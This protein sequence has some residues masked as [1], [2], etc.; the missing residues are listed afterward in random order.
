MIP[1]LGVILLRFAYCRF[2]AALGGPGMWRTLFGVTF[3]VILGCGPET[4][5]P[6]KSETPKAEAPD[7]GQSFEQATRSSDDPPKDAPKPV[8]QTITKK[9]AFKVVEQVKEVWPKISLTDASGKPRPIRV[10]METSLGP[11]VLEL[12]PDWAP[13]HVRNFL[14]LTR[15]GYFDGLRVERITQM[16]TPQGPRVSWLEAGCPLGDGKIPSGSIGYWLRD[17]KV[18]AEATGEGLVGACRDGPADSGAT[19]FFLSLQSQR[20]E[21]DDRTFFGRVVQGMEIVRKISL[22]PVI[23][24]EDEPPGSYSPETPVEI[25]R[26]VEEVVNPGATPSKP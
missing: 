6:S 11:I 9:S 19:R 13:N 4:K 7:L 25:L 1:L 8:D 22:R 26:V 16:E 12:R 3:L 5:T 17:E 18:P 20:A 2:W 24:L 14:A 15:V 21:G 10:R 23:V